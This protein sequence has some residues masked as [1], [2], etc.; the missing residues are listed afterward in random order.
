MAKI[1]RYTPIF[2]AGPNGRSLMA[3][4]PDGGL[5]L[6]DI[7]G[8]R[9]VSIPDGASIPEQHQD[10]FLELMSPLPDELKEA[11]KASSRACQLI[12]DQMQA[13]IRERY[14]LEDEQYFARIG[15]GASLGA[16]TFLPGEMESLLEFGRFVEEVREWGRSKRGDI[17]L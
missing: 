9:Y 8:V 7:D 2:E 14:S 1:Y 16:Y 17:G 6:C 11:I 5:E 4:L 10:I 13:K 12:S 3:R 15:V